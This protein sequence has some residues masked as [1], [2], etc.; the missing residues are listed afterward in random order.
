MKKRQAS[1]LIDE[2]VLPHTL[3]AGK[4]IF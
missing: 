2:D 1:F 3:S 4:L